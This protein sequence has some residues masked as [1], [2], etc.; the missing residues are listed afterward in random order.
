MLRMHLYCSMRLD[1]LIKAIR[2]ISSSCID[3][4]LNKISTPKAQ[5]LINRI[6]FQYHK[7]SCSK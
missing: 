1:N 7:E 3:V 6:K 4:D 2:K 5:Y